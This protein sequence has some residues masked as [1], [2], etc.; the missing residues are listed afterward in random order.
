MKNRE[1]LPAHSLWSLVLIGIVA[2]PSAAAFAEPTQPPGEDQPKPAEASAVS[3][4]KVSWA[5]IVKLVDKHPR[6]AEGQHH[7]A[8]AKASVDA[9][10]AV[11][12]PSLEAGFSYGQALDGSASRF[13]WG[14]GLSFPLGWIAQRGAQIDAASAEAQVASAESKALRRDVLLTLRVLFWNLVYEQERVAALG[15][16]N[17][18]TAALVKTVK[19]RVEK[20]ESRS[21]EALRVEVEAEKIAGELEVARLAQNSRS[22]QLGAWFGAGR[23]QQLVAVADLTKLEPPMSAKRAKQKT[24]SEHPAIAAA[25]A[26]VQVLRAKVTIEQRARVPSFSIEAFTDHELDRRAYGVGLAIDLP[27]WNWNTGNIQ[28]SQSSLAAGKLQ[29]EAERLELEV[30]TIEAQAT[31]QAGVTLA[32]RYKDRILPRAAS[33]AQIIERTYKLGEAS[34]L[35]VIDAR[36]T[37]LE[38]WHQFLAALVQTQIDCSRLAALVGEELQ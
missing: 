7:I 23:D 34:L 19:R 13:E 35:E 31:C 27:I 20:G 12:N 5:E 11:P 33:A 32:A 16:L 26:R 3:Q 14:L 29:L 1:L 2:W 38:T 36:R 18:Q 30:A 37:L 28:Q 17:S 21:V 10:G 15:E 22:A 24:L 4:V 8:A 25:K 6:I 9:A